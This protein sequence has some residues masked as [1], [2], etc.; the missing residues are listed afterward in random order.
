MKTIGRILIILS[1][2][3]FTLSLAMYLVEGHW[4][5]NED[6][7]SLGNAIWFSLVTVTTVGYGDLSPSSRGGQFVTVCLFAFSVGVFSFLLSKIESIV[8]ERHRMREL[9]MDGTNFKGHIVICGWCRIA[10][11]ALKELLAAERQV[12]VITEDANSIPLIRQLGDPS[13]LFVTVGDPSSEEALGRANILVARTVIAA[14]DDDTQNLITALEIRRINPNAR[15][16]VATKRA[17]LRSTLTSTGVTYVASPFELSGRLVASAAFEPE[18]ALFIDDVTSGA[19]DDENDDNG[20]DLQQFSIPPNSALVNQTINQLN[21]TL[22]QIQGPMLLAIA[23]HTGGGHYQIYPHPAEN[24]TIYPYD[25]LIVLGN[26][27]QNQR[28]G[29]MLGVIQGR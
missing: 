27:S 23:K 7:Q 11:V 29:E 20:Y 1:V 4:A 22:K 10:Q 13:L 17:E 15:M 18:V 6:F 28:V 25:S 16:V 9:G 21:A 24:M 19:A 14:S 5:G 2:I 12:A 3:F 8:S 26:N